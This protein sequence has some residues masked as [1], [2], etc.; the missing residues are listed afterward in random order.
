MVLYRYASR[1]AW[2]VYRC[3]P[4]H[5]IINHAN[6]I[7]D[8]IISQSIQMTSL[9]VALKLSMADLKPDGGRGGK[10]KALAANSTFAEDDANGLLFGGYLKSP[11]LISDLCDKFMVFFSKKK[12][13]FNWR[14]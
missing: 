5:S 9:R 1:Y 2:I 10:R 13:V 3:K 12:E 6:Q 11:G 8:I 4:K 14:R 7:T